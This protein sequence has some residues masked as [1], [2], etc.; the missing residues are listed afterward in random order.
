MVLFNRRGEVPVARRAKG[1]TLI[2]LLVVIA[3]IGV[4][5]ALLLPAVQAARESARRLQ[6]QGNLKQWGIALHNYAD[7]HGV[8]PMGRVCNYALPAEGRCF[9]AFA[10]L[11][12]FVEQGKTYDLVNFSC[13]PDQSFSGNP[14]PE[15]ATALNLNLPIFLC[16]S[17]FG[18]KLQGESGVHNYPLCTGTTFAVSPRNLAGTPLTGVFFE[19]SATRWRDMTDGLSKTVCIGEQVL[20]RPGGPTTWDG[21]SVTDGFVLTRGNA[22]V[23]PNAPA[24]FDYESQCTGAG[25]ALQQTRGSRWLYGA[26][27]HSMYNHHRPPNDPRA[28]CR[29]GLPHSI[30]SDP[31]WRDLSLSVAAHSRHPGIVNALRC[32]GSVE[33]V[34]STV[35]LAVWQALATI[36]GGETVSSE[37]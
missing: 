5:I 33:A 29:G 17:D 12:P 23:P 26:P 37:P 16:P 18:K 24:L 4:L 13:N 36:A 20:S 2:E 1:F 35:D 27:G 14:A 7:A 15:N 10:M 25:L 3:I 34:S 22:N 28:D 9:S 31:Y 21:T 19:N 32:D 6:C 30:R 8:L 11:L